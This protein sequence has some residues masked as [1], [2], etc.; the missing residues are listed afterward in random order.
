VDSV[1][2]TEG[3]LARAG[4]GQRTAELEDDAVRLGRGLSRGLL[5]ERSIASSVRGGSSTLFQ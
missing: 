1:S 3:G 2:L 4:A 5:D